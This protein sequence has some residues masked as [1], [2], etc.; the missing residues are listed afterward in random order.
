[1]HVKVDPVCHASFQYQEYTD[2]LQFQQG[3][4]VVSGPVFVPVCES[5]GN[6]T[7]NVLTF[8]HFSKCLGE[9]CL[10]PLVLIMEGNWKGSFK[11]IVL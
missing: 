11:L 7:I 9:S 6:S 5:T 3:L 1:M 10:L 2:G 8:R 4:A